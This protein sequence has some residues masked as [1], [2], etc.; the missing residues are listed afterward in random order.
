MALECLAKILQTSVWSLFKSALP[1]DSISVVASFVFSSCDARGSFLLSRKLRTI[2]EV[3]RTNTNKTLVA[4]VFMIDQI[5]LLT[6][7]PKP[8][9]VLLTERRS[10]SSHQA[11]KP[12]CRVP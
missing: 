6:N 11:A 8:L 9:S 10:H 5:H 3:T 12:K 1:Q 2:H 7:Q 4:Y